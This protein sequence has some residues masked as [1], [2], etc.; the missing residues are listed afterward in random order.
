MNC[1]AL[2]CIYAIFYDKVNHFFS[3]HFWYSFI[4]IIPLYV[5]GLFYKEPIGGYAACIAVVCIS[6]K[7]TFKSKITHFLGKISLGI[8]LFL[9]ISSLI[10]QP[11]VN[12]QYLWV[13]SNTILIFA[14][15][16][17]LYFVEIMLMRIKTKLLH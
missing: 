10:M 14:L 15:S 3:K 11:F 2:G 5:F 12:N 1:F 8:Y 6:Q 9:Y 17:G 16:I 7:Y 4:F 13:I